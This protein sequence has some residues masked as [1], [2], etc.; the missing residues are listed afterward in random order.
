MA[1]FGEIGK[2]YSDDA[3]DPLIGGKLYFYESGTTTLKQT[4]SDVNLSIE[5]SNPVILSAAGRQPNIFFN[6][7][8]RVTLTT[9][10]GQQIETRD[11]EGGSFD[12]GV[13]SPWNS[14][15]IYNKN[16]IV[17]ASNGLFYVSIINGSQGNDPL[18][19][20]LN[21]T[22]IKFIRVWN[23]SEIYTTSQIVQGSD[24]FLYRSLTTNNVGN[25]PIADITNWDDA[26]KAASL[27]PVIRSSAKTYAYRS[28]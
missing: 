7:S 8:A 23:S 20:I 5:N 4:Y 22:Q 11:P 17:I 14:L 19:D 15:T 1:R 26:T 9:S 6:G 28:L 2:Q 12:E 16:D 24:G 25:D 21:W 13:F 10:L 3:G 27:P 18:T